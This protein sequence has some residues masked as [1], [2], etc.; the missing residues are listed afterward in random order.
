MPLAYFKK[1]LQSSRPGVGAATTLF[2][3]VN[4][5]VA[6]GIELTGE[7]LCVPDLNSLR[8]C[9]YAPGH[10]SVMV[11]FQHKS[12]VPGPDGNLSLEVDL[13]PRTLLARVVKYVIHVVFVP[14][15]NVLL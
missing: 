7:Y 11:T 15:V 6:E 4:L 13:C 3:L 8:V 12:P 14:R 1:L 5:E 10:A 2:G 9:P